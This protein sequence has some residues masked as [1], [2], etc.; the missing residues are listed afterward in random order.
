MY[1]RATL[2]FRLFLAVALPLLLAASASAQI[3]INE[4]VI[5]ERNY[6]DDLPDTREFVELY[7]AGNTSVNLENW[8][9]RIW[10]LVDNAERFVDILPDFELA[11]GEYFV[12]GHA[13]VANLDHQLPAVDLWA[14][15]RALVLELRNPMDQTQ[16]AVAFEVYRTGANGLNNAT[17]EQRA[18]VGNGY[19]ARHF[20]FNNAA[21]N[22]QTSWGRYR[23]GADTNRNG[24]DFGHLPL[25]PGESN[26]IPVVEGYRVPNV[27]SLTV[28]T[29]PADFHASFIMPKVIDPT[30]L[31]AH[32]ARVIP[33]SP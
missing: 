14:D 3:V 4:L 33:A 26:N 19:Q 22:V 27:D 9:L 29:E 7:N 5:N 16:D 17:P 13:A 2:G 23:D 21:P 8:D 28:E 30:Q 1:P 32:N 31:S 20:S 18:H 11:P 24:F 10:D 6:S 25:T 15:A 12:M